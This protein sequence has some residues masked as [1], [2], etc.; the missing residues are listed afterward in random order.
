MRIEQQNVDKF[1]SSYDI[2]NPRPD[3]GFLPWPLID[4]RKK[5]AFFAAEICIL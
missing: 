5:G 1:K 3:F 4:N 2:W